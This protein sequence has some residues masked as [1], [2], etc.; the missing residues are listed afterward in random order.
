M[1]LEEI[2]EA[3][4]SDVLD[5]EEWS[6]L[7]NISTEFNDQDMELEEISLEESQPPQCTQHGVCSV[8][9]SKRNS[10]T[11]SNAMMR[12]RATPEQKCKR[13]MLLK[14]AEQITHAIYATAAV[15]HYFILCGGIAVEL[16]TGTQPVIQAWRATG[17]AAIGLEL[18]NGHDVTQP[19][20][21]TISLESITHPL[22]PTLQ[23]VDTGTARE[24]AHWQRRFPSANSFP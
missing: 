24:T 23:F 11:P 16:F 20:T 4:A 1:E 9:R 19:D 22:Q 7:G 3:H 2:D 18:I 12:R 8:L 21:L 5:I 13:A 10:Q 6:P 17:V 14:S 15:A